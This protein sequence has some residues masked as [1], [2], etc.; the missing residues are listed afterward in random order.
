MAASY[1]KESFA[2][3]KLLSAV[4]LSIAILM[5]ISAVNAA[6]VEKKDV[7]NAAQLDSGIIKVAYNSGTDKKLKVMVEKNGQKIYYNLR[8]DG[9]A[10]SFPLQFGNGE[11]KVSVMENVEGTKY[12]YVTSENLSLSLKNQNELYLA[13]V[14]N[15]NWNEDME[16]IR[17]AKELTRGLKSDVEKVAVIYNYI[18]NYVKYD[19]K[20]LEN[21]SSDYLP[22]IDATLKTNKG[23]CY[24]YSSTFAAMLRS[25]GV[26]TKLV[27]GY[28]KNV[29]G[30]HAWN[31]VY[32]NE[33]ESWQTIDSTYD[34]Q[35]KEAGLK[36]TMVKKSSD[37]TKVNEY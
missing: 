30:Y 9:V 2:M 15:V 7:F 26:P 3:R 11:Y 10:E 12:K 23:I 1:R 33:T 29:N 18:V 27:K 21:L 14:Q 28:A 13:S 34:S 20:K 36:Y 4:I 37:Y 24:D 32:D 19:Y 25:V 31:E 35:M 22:S 6:T 5:N 17:K 8:N 16:A